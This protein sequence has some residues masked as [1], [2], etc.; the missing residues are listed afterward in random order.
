MTLKYFGMSIKNFY[1]EG[2]RMFDKR[3]LR[4]YS[5]TKFLFFFFPVI[6]K[7]LDSLNTMRTVSLVQKPC[8]QGFVEVLE[9]VRIPTRPSR[10]EVRHSPLIVEVYSHS[11]VQEECNIPLRQDHS[12][13]F[14]LWMHSDVSMSRYPRPKN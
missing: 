1:G 12:P 7:E 6:L 10:P 2:L 4:N 13:T 8:C 9:N 14:K 5:V 11:R 3:F